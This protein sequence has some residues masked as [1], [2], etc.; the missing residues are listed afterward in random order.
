MSRKKDEPRASSSVTV[1]C[2]LARLVRISAG[3][4][5]HTSKPSSASSR[6]NQREYRSF[7]PYT[8]ADSSLLQVWIEFLSFSIIVVQSPF[9]ALAS[10]FHK[11]AIC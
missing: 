7:H 1:F 3:S 4:P 9:T 5:I 10:L 6:S 2:F 8:H 11:K